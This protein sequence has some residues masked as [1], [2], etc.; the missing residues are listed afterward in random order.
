MY[1]DKPHCYTPSANTWSQLVK[2]KTPLII[3]TKIKRYPEMNLLR[4][5]QDPYALNSIEFLS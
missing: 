3:A 2:R 4:N 5:G 1:T